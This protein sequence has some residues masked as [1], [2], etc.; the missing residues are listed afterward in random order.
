MKPQTLVCLTLI[1]GLMAAEPVAPLV[2]P[3]GVPPVLNLPAPP[4]PHAAACALVE[5]EI[6]S[7]LRP[8]LPPFSRVS[9]P[10]VIPSYQQLVK[11][12]NEERLPFTISIS[13]HFQQQDSVSGYVRLSDNAIFIYRPDK[14][15]HIRSTLD[16]RFAPVKGKEATTE[17]Q[18]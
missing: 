4:V 17:K 15:D 14:T 11:V 7:R 16:P 10:M 3:S 2:A 9:P 13:N 8:T 6:V 5:T 12:G 18:T 1:T